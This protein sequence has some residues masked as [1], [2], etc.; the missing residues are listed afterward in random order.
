[1]AQTEDKCKK[2]GC[3]LKSD[4]DDGERYCLNSCTTGGQ[5]GEQKGTTES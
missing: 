1:M 4:G 3:V 5:I 2:C